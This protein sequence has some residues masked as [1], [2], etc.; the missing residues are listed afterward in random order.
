MIACAFLLSRVPLEAFQTG[1]PCHCGVDS[2][3]RHAGMSQARWKRA[4]ASIAS[5]TP[6]MPR[7]I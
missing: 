7:N 6:T 3:G 5:S 2:Q 1:H 4:T